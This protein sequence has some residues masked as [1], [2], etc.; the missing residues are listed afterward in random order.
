MEFAGE[1]PSSSLNYIILLRNPQRKRVCMKRML[2]SSCVADRLNGKKNTIKIDKSVEKLIHDDVEYRRRGK[3]H[4][5][6]W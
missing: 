4:V 5:W 2:R 6:N 3:E 1:T